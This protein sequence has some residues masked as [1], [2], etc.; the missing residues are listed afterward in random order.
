MLSFEI[1]NDLAVSGARPW[2][3]VMD[4]GN[5]TNVII[6]WFALS[7]VCYRVM[8][9]LSDDCY[10]DFWQEWGTCWKAHDRAG[11]SHRRF[12]RHNHCNRRAKRR[13]KHVTDI[14]SEEKGHQSPI[15]RLI[16]SMPPPLPFHRR[17]KC[18]SPISPQ[19]AISGNALKEEVRAITTTDS[20]VE[21]S[22]RSSV[23]DPAS[24]QK[25][26]KKVSKS[27]IG[28]T[29]KPVV[30]TSLIDLARMQRW[31]LLEE[32]L[33]V[34]RRE[35]KYRDADGLMP[36]HWACSGGPPNSVVQAL[37][38][39]YPKAARRVDS[40]GSTALHFASHYGGSVAVVETLIEAHPPAMR[41]QD[42][43]GRT[44][45]YHA[46]KKSAGLAVLRALLKADPEMATAPCI[47]PPKDNEGHSTK[48][49]NQRHLREQTPLHAVWI[50]ALSSLK[51]QPRRSQGRIWDKAV[52]LL[53]A[54]Y[55]GYVVDKDNCMSP[56]SSGS[57]TD[58][59]EQRTFRLLHA[60][61]SLDAF[62]PKDLLP[63]LLK[64]FPEQ[65]RE[66]DDDGRLP[67]AIA[68]SLTQVTPERS[69]TLLKL[70]LQ[71]Y[72]HAAQVTDLDGRSP[73]VL[74]LASGKRWD[75]GVERLLWAAPDRLHI[76]DYITGLYPAML[77]ATASSSSP[78]NDDKDDESCS[79]EVKPLLDYQS[80]SS[81]TGKV[82]D[83]RRRIIK[84]R[85][86]QENN[87]TTSKEND[88]AS[89]V[90]TIF[91]LLQANPAILRHAVD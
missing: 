70:L 3:T 19:K 40:D 27:K 88:E 8:Y 29:L 24:K 69:D 58:K 21:A 20:S 15:S 43:Y 81:S 13:Q 77:A 63:Y 86:T 48:T 25:K 1:E 2:S 33:T 10:S 32:R 16:C 76:Q 82:L 87:S 73:L 35:A 14:M 53:Q 6:L 59:R 23:E 11:Q 71:E 7:A 68:A 51:S 44:P 39:A 38:T 45:L 55:L 90:S 56:K 74:A 26:K 57:E 75:W 84:T 64:Q 78:K 89:H 28:R 31:P 61:V 47:P 85:Q 42:K 91:E 50:A 79:N 49:S 52:L 54:A 41:V 60:A 37:L 65:V 30:Q 67:L 62:L 80:S 72:P 46:V 18:M 36:L 9:F 22:Q 5:V 34:S 83:L 12:A 4:Q 17:R 66:A